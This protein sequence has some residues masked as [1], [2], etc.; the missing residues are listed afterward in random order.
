MALVFQIWNQ[1]LGRPFSYR[2]DGLVQT[3]FVK[4]VLDNGWYDHNVFLGF[5]FGQNHADFALGGDN[6]HYLI[7]KFLGVFF[8]DAVLVTNIYFLI[9]FLLVSLTAFFVLRCLGIRRSCALPAAVLFS[10]LPYHFLRGTG[11]LIL[12]SYW[13]VPVA[14]LLI[15][16]ILQPDPP[17]FLGKSAQRLLILRSRRSY[18]CVLGALVIAST[19]VYYAAFFVLLAPTVGLLRGLSTRDFRGFFSGAILAAIVA[20]G[21]LVNIAPTLLYQRS[22]GKNDQV[23]QRTVAESDY[24][25]LRPIQMIVPIPGHR[26]PAFSNLTAESLTAPNNSEGTSYLGL[27][28]SVGFLGLLVVAC[29]S[30]TGGAAWNGLLR[31]LAVPI[32]P[33]ILFGVTGGLSWVL[34]LAGLTEIR[35]W[36]RIS[37]FM[38][39]L[40]LTA[41]ALG[42]QALLARLDWRKWA[43]V[44]VGTGLIIIGVLD[45]TSSAIVP[46]ARRFE[47]EYENDARFVGAVERR[48]SSG[49]AVFQ[50]PYLP[51][52]EAE[53]DR[54]PNLGDYDPI[55]GYLHSD[56]LKWSYGGMRGR[57][58][59]WQV[60]V[61]RKPPRELLA[62]VTAVGFR[63]LWI[64]RN[65][66]AD[67]AQALESA[68]SA[69]LGPSALTSDD[70]RFVFFELGDLAER[71]RA[72]LGDEGLEALRRQT[73]GLPAIRTGAGFSEAQPGIGA[74]TLLGGAEATLL[75]R[76][77][78]SSQRDFLLKGLLSIAGGAEGTVTISAGEEEMRILLSRSAPT[79][80]STQVSLGPGQHEIRFHTDVTEPAPG[81]PLVLESF[82][83]LPVEP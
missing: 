53:L 6:L 55:R 56:V 71:Q 78:T 50:L 14:C 1:P 13:S 47:A 76:N 15:L 73:L 81:S 45:Q 10:F 75:V 3:A 5:P 77:R 29:S 54:P 32:V 69:I 80:L 25:A 61:V 74:T 65:G 33:A 42:S 40:S 12:A 28:G 44:L 59:D 49:D 64:D 39:F 31:D 27:I 37:V 67:Q 35:S 46:D 68:F 36:N 57:E 23:A 8:H 17:F 82:E 79:D 43:A 20:T 18:L 4:T 70:G 72:K 7:I 83:V 9:G 2:R 34:G 30:V 38:A 51:Y 41:V 48:L 19:S 26:I 60:S 62:A 22:H 24:Y 21:L 11:H 52:P 63:G 16:L 58:S 66:Y